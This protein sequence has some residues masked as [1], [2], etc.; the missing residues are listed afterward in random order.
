MRRPRGRSRRHLVASAADQHGQYLF[1][2][3]GSDAQQDLD[4]DG[5]PNVEEFLNASTPVAPPPVPDGAAVP[6]LPLRVAHAGGAVTVTWDALR[7]TAVA[8]NLYYGSLDDG[9]RFTGAA[10]NLPPTGTATLNLPD[11]IWLL[12]AATDGVAT[13]GSYARD[14]S[15]AE[16]SYVGAGLVCPGITQHAPDSNCP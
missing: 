16:L 7:C 5:Y 12:V 11:N 13:D 4:G 15:G 6:G 1:D 3:S 14:L 8:V 10:C 2:T 9:T